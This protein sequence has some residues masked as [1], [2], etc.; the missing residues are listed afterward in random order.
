MGGK[1]FGGNDPSPAKLRFF[2]NEIQI[3]DDFTTTATDGV[4]SQFSTKWNSGANTSATI[5]IVDMNLKY[6]GNDFSLDD[7]SF[8]SLCTDVAVKPYTFTAGTPAKATEVNANFD[9]LYQQINAL[10][11]QVQAL[12]EIVC[13]DHPTADICK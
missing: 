7:L 12:K 4:W 11:C 8:S 6:D 13:K 2:I 3:G 5:R 1:I 10:N 9:T